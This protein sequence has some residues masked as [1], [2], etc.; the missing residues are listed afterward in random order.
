MREIFVCLTRER[1]MIWEILYAWWEEGS[2]SK[3]ECLGGS[4]SLNAGELTAMMILK[5]AAFTV[6][7]DQEFFNSSAG[8]TEIHQTPYTLSVPS[9]VM[10]WSA[11]GLNFGVFRFFVNHTQTQTQNNAFSICACHDAFYACFVTH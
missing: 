1:F 9:R 3:K 10:A 6:A 7:L 8:V 11:M 4:G 2:I 5:M